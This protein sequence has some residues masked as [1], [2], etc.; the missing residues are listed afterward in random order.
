MGLCDE[1]G[2]F[3]LVMD[4]NDEYGS[5]VVGFLLLE[6]V[7]DAR[8]VTSLEHGHGVPNDDFRDEL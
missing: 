1:R 5:L 6:I 3:L 4:F 8:L 2:W 7:N